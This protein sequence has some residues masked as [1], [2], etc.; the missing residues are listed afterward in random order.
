LRAN[1]DA[2]GAVLYVYNSGTATFASTLPANSFSGNT[3]TRHPSGN[4][5]GNCYVYTGYKDGT[6]NG[7]CG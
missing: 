7:S 5:H 3:L 6:I 4:N 2:E 1:Q